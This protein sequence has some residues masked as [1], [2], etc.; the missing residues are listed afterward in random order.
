[1]VQFFTFVRNFFEDKPSELRLECLTGAY[2]PSV[3]SL[4]PESTYV[5]NTH[6]GTLTGVAD[7]EQDGFQYSHSGELSGTES[8]NQRHYFIGEFMVTCE[9]VSYPLDYEH[10]QDVSNL[11]DRLG[12]RSLDAVLSDDRVT[13]QVTNLRLVTP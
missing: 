7:N 3:V 13:V 6:G 5:L 1:M 11:L 8:F 10:E 4:R 12:H 2:T 9:G